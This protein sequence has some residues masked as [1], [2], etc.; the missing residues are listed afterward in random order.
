MLP[1]A[2]EYI[3]KYNSLSEM[4]EGFDRDKLFEELDD[5]WWDL[6]VDEQ[7]VVWSAVVAK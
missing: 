7:D 4:P 2:Q 1:K 6:S 5:M 3:E